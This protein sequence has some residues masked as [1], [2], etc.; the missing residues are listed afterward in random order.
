MASKALT[1]SPLLDRKLL[2]SASNGLSGVEIEQKFGIPAAQAMLRI[3]QLLEN[4]RNVFDEIEERQLL[5][6]SLKRMKEQVET[7][8]VDTDNPKHIEAVTKL[9]LAIDRITSKQT[10]IT[11]SELSIVTESQARAL[12]GLVESAYAHARKLL[13]EE[14]GSVID[15]DAIDAAFQGGLRIEAAQAKK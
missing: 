13:A 11:E 12:L 6:L 8:G 9:I 14:Y 1:T 10:Q 5:V 3:K 7:A 15:L 4:G 2:E